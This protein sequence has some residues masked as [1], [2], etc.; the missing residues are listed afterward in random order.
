[1][2]ENK[3]ETTQNNIFEIQLKNATEPV[4]IKDSIIKQLEATKNIVNE[5]LQQIATVKNLINQNDE[6]SFDKIEEIL[7]SD[8]YQLLKENIQKAK[9]VKKIV[10]TARKDSKRFLK[11]YIKSFDD[12][13]ELRLN[14]YGVDK[15]QLLSN[16][17]SS[18]KA[19]VLQKRKDM[20]VTALNKFFELTI[21]NYAY[22][23]KLP[24]PTLQIYLN[25]YPKFISGSKTYSENKAKDELT[26]FITGSLKVQQY[27]LETLSEKG[28]LESTAYNIWKNYLQELPE[29]AILVNQIENA[30]VEYQNAIKQEEIRLANEKQRLNDIAIQQAKQKEVLKAQQLK[31]AQQQQVLQQQANQIGIQLQSDSNDVLSLTLN[32]LQ[33][34]GQQFNLQMLLAIKTEDTAINQLDATHFAVKRLL[35]VPES[36]MKNKTLQLLIKY[37]T[38]LVL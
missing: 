4:L 29:D 38:A 34:I 33:S 30:K 2:T 31:Q 6:N 24:K 25:K 35:N 8:S 14:E 9:K 32:E 13:L 5:G 37:Y 20:R 23:Q 27:I 18:L 21:A 10:D 16:E 7:E 28:I 11:D 26:G 17:D 19:E 12:Y 3:N 22:Q 15:L 36:D 1:M